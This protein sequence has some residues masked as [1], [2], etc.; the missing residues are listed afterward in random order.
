MRVHQILPAAILI[1]TALHIAAQE[2]E[3]AT[4]PAC[5]GG[6]R[7][8]CVPDACSRRSGRDRTRQ[9][10]LPNQLCVLPWR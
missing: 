10:H 6:S 8:G 2:H 5:A 7:C 9:R 1:V 4:A 3:A